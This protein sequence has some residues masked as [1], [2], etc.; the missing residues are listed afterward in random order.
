MQRGDWCVYGRLEV[1]DEAN[2]VMARIRVIIWDDHV[3]MFLRR[4]AISDANDVSLR[5]AVDC[6]WCC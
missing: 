1:N 2:L 5:G 6:Y 4:F 3:A